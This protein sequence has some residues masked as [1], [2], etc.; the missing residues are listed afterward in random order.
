MIGIIGAMQIEIDGL[1]AM[2]EAPA[3][4]TISGI[5]YT[6]GRLHG[7][8]VVLAVCGIGKVFAAICAQTMVLSY[9]VNAVINTGVAGT[10]SP[11]I[12]IQDIAIASDLVQ[13]DMDTSAI[14]DPP[15]LLSGINVIHLP[16]QPRLVSLAEE[17]AAEQGFHTETGT[18]A[19]GDQ[20]VHTDAEKVRIR[21]VFGGIAAEMEGG[22]IAQVCYVNQVPCVVIRAISDD[23]SGN[24][25]ADYNQFAARAAE[26][27][28]RLVSE[29]VKR[30]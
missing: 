16:C 21:T 13:H 3:S 9:P 25:P 26:R 2:L 17:I 19:S 10:L 14:G 6:S 12:G 5:E 1:R 28:I 8:D 20:F 18:I 29:L 24:S 22:S 23:A 7:V 15:G 27:S 30:Y 4:R 11:N